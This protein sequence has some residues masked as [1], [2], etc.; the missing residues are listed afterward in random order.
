MPTLNGFHNL[1]SDAG[2]ISDPEPAFAPASA[3]SNR[4]VKWAITGLIA[5]GDLTIFAGPKKCGKSLVAAHLAACF[6]KGVPFAPG[7]FVEP[8]ARG[9]VLLYNGERAIDC[10]AKPRCQA[11]GADLDRLCIS[12]NAYTLDEVIADIEKQPHDVRAALIDPLKAVADVAHISD[13]K[14][15]FYIRKLETLARDRD[16]AIVLMHHISLRGRKSTDPTDYIQGK[17][18]WVEA[19]LNACMLCPLGDGYILQNVASNKLGGHRFEYQIVSHTLPDGIET[20]RIE[21]LGS[22]E[23]D[24]VD[25]LN[26]QTKG[27][28]VKTKLERAVEWLLDYLKD[29]PK[30]RNDVYAAAAQAGYSEATLKR[31]KQECGVE[32]RKRQGDGLSEWFIPAKAD[33]PVDPVG[34][35][36]P[37]A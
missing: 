37:P 27:I 9:A 1:P 18:V 30:L 24:I 21:M 14:A 16:M 36:E 23:H 20:E 3:I 13:T 12:G 15:R 8:R 4:A 19:A 2:L 28:R 26:G 5:L 10:F 22:S 6:T 17:R 25:A 34:S 33:E 7:V 35:V 32:D 29:G 11:A 31:A